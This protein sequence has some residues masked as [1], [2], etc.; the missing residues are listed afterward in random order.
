M[1]QA[2]IHLNGI[3]R[4][5]ALATLLC[6]V[7]ATIGCSGALSSSHHQAN[8]DPLHLGV[9]PGPLGVPIPQTLEVRLGSEPSDRIVSLSLTTSSVQMTNSGAQ[10]LELLTAPVTVEFTRSAIVTAPVVV[11]NIYQDTYSALI[12]ADMTGQVVFYDSNGQLA[13]QSLTVPGRTV[14]LTPNLVLALNPQTLSISLNLAQTFTVN[15]S[16]VTVNP[17]VVT[18]SST[19]PLPP[20]APAVGQPETGSSS[21]LVG[22][23][24]TVDTVAK[25]ISMQ[26][27]SGDALQLSYDNTTQFMNCSVATLPGMMIETEDQTQSSGAVLATR[28]TLIENSASSSELYGLLAGHAPDGASYN[29][30]VEGGAGLNVSTG[31][32]GTK[33]TVDWIAASYSVNTSRLDMSGSQ[34]LVFDE[35]R[36]FPG[37]FVA[38]QWDSLIVPDPD[39]S[40][41][42]YLQPRMI[43]LQEQTISGQVLNYVFDAGT[44]T[45]TFTLTVA[46]SAPIKI[47]NSGLTSITVRQISQTYLRNTPTFVNGDSVKVRGLLF[48]DPNYN[49]GN[50]QPPDPVAFIMV[51]DRIS[52]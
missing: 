31:L 42:G 28:V 14:A 37:Q 23:V 32:I 22:T 8:G 46:D 49:N 45:G 11:R 52:K 17:I 21:F 38:V 12:F 26:P 18:A 13:T 29:L 34:D 9:V 4:I 24:T 7:V 2:R 39:S 25:T 5:V 35:A 19:V 33:V 6:A 50:Y 27:T 41:A 15:T 10:N 3:A 20:V 47:L 1:S 51:A 48:V 36:T 43:E 30:I 16:S 40:N 44:Q